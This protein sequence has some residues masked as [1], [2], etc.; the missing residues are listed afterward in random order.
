[1]EELYIP[2]TLMPDLAAQ[3]VVPHSAESYIA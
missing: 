1:M 3:L 2:L